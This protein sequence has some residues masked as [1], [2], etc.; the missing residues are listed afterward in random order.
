MQVT[1]ITLQR[2]QKHAREGDKADP[3]KQE[4]PCRIIGSLSV[5]RA[6]GRFSPRDLGT[7]PEINQLLSSFEGQ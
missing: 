2:S 7:S 3:R 5:P 6:Y 1:R 4:K